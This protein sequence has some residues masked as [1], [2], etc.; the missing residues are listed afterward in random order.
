MTWFTFK[1]SLYLVGVP[2][3]IVPRRRGDEETLLGPKAFMSCHWPTFAR[4][5]VTSPHRADQVRRVVTYC[6]GSWDRWMRRLPLI[7]RL[8]WC[9][10]RIGLPV[11]SLRG[12]VRPQEM[13]AEQE[14]TIGKVLGRPPK[15][16]E[17]RMRQSRSFEGRSTKCRVSRVEFCNERMTRTSSC[18]DRGDGRCSDPWFSDSRWVQLYW[19]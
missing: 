6:T 17:V 11:S 16:R 10:I 13:E 14:W 7:S 18:E 5:Q 15:G 2:Q 9:A 1:C 8:H 4:G 3:I 12:S 19:D